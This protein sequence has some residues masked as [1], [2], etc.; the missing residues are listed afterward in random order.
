MFSK[1]SSLLFKSLA[2]FASI[3]LL[4]SATQSNNIKADFD[5]IYKEIKNTYAP[6]RRV[7]VFDVTLTQK[8]DSTIINGA[9]TEEKALNSLKEAL[10]KGGIEAT[11]SVE[12]LP[13]SKL[14]DKVYGIA[15]QSVINLRMD[16]GYAEEAGTQ[17]M[18]GT[19][20]KLLR[21]RDG[22][23]QVI[24]PEGYISWVTSGSLAELTEDDF[25]KYIES[26]K[27]ILTTRYTVVTEKTSEKSQPICDAVWGNVFLD[28][29]KKGKF[30]KVGLADGREGYILTK[31][32]EP[33]DK[34]LSKRNP[35]PEDIIET[36]K[37]FIG[38]PYMWGATSIKAVDCSGF[39]KSVYFLNGIILARDASQQCYTGDN[40]NI[41]EYVDGNKYTRESLKNLKT[42][43][44]IFFG[45]KATPEKKERI[46]HVGI[47]IGE[48]IFI[49][50]ATKVRIN[51]LIPEDSN[52][53]EGSV[54]L[55]RAQRILG[56]ENKGKGIITIDNSIYVK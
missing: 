50:S 39:T 22:W 7:K 30:T 54:R 16:D 19:P 3:I 56:N 13:S 33:F 47:Y 37:Q 48:G 6:D 42:G 4:C 25:N 23:T 12:L 40:I 21:K 49:H 52:Y 27:V 20:L 34:W 28:L 32:I 17:V 35:T 51:S 31:N 44:L 1:I 18:M 9:T 43:D 5:T 41:S 45:R 10:K 55:V 15:T 24:T 46:S 8:G 36:A 2:P 11:F 53:Y 29:G 38:V 26:K 14:G